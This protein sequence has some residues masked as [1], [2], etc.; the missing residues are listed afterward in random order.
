MHV[1]YTHYRKQLQ[2]LQW[3][4]SK[5]HWVLKSP[6]HQRGLPALMDLFPDALIIQTHRDPCNVAPSFCSLYQVVHELT[7]ENAVQK[8]QG[9]QRLDWLSEVNDI[10]LNLRQKLGPDRFIDVGFSEL[11]RDP[12][13]IVQRIYDRA[14]MKLTV[15]AENEMRGWHSA[16][17][18][19]K[20]G[21]HRYSLEEFGLSTEQVHTRLKT[22]YEAFGE[23]L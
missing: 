5:S 22:Y 18:Q 20:R 1:P 10:T 13:G 23:Y 19:H 11:M 17:P 4:D 14:G 8:L 2:T 7:S 12:I 15:A 3:R 9:P 16:N 21:V 6:Y